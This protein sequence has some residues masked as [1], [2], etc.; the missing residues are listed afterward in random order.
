[1]KN[2]NFKTYILAVLGVMVTILLVVG[3]TYAYWTLTKQQT[4]EN[5]INTAC[6]NITFSG[7][8]DISLDKAYPMTEEQLDSFLSTATP[9][10]FTIHNECSD[11]A[12]A[13]IN[14]ES[15]TVDGKAL[16]DQWIDAILYEDT[17]STNLNSSKKLTGNTS[18][19]ENKVIADAKHAYKLHTFTLPANGDKDFY[20]L[21]Y[22]DSETPM[23]DANMNASWKGKITLSAEYEPEE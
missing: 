13:S 6:L 22:M 16:D 18:N 19:D 4:G 14:L 9:Y 20:L 23:E 11:K 10:H 12:S 5:V 17:Y 1:M 15:L 3:V 7:Q 2:N 8:D 21:L